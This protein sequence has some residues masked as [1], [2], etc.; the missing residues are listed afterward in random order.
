[1]SRKMILSFPALCF[2][3]LTFFPARLAAQDAPSVA[4]A[5]RRAREQKKASAKPATIITDD[6]LH[7]ASATPATPGSDVAPAPA[8]AQADSSAPAPAQEGGKPETASNDEKKEKL[9]A[10]KKQLADLQERVNVLQREIALEQD[11]FYRNPDYV[12]DTAGKQKL[13]ALRDDLQQQESELS[14]L[15]A[16]MAELD[17][18]DSK[19]ASST[20]PETPA[21]PQQ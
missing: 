12:H 16:K 15:K 10:L 19:P 21:P 5:A 1:M 9:A 20:G 6:T 11:N 18:G 13:D 14:D 3:A 4:E 7:P 17:S 8:P 2:L